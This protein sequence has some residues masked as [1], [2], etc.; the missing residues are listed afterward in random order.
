MQTFIFRDMLK[1]YNFAFSAKNTKYPIDN[2]IK[3]TLMNDKK[4][5][6]KYSNII[7]IEDD[8]I[9]FDKAKATINIKVNSITC[10]KRIVFFL[11]I[12]KIFYVKAEKRIASD[13]Q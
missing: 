2:L 13:Y 3:I 8:Y 7:Q 1:A 12:N 9:I 10:V 6:D 11:Y 5:L 4:N